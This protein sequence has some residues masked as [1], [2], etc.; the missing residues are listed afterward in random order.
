MGAPKSGMNAR[1]KRLLIVG[2]PAARPLVGCWRE[3][4]LEVLLPLGLDIREGRIE[5]NA[6]RLQLPDQFLARVAIPDDVLSPVVV[7]EHPGASSMFSVDQCG[8]GIRALSMGVPVHSVAAEDLRD[9][10]AEHHRGKQPCGQRNA[11]TRGAGTTS[12]NTPSTGCVDLSQIVRIEQCRQ[13]RGAHTEAH[14]P[15]DSD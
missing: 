1:T 8:T 9:Q 15:G 11:A 3:R 2:W 5:G 6:A 4:A 10:Q 14:S 7:L 13:I 12:W